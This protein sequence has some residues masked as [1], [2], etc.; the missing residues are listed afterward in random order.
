[1]FF[2]GFYAFGETAGLPIVYIID[3]TESLSVFNG[4]YSPGEDFQ[5]KKIHFLKLRQGASIGGFCWMVGWLVGCWKKV[6]KISYNVIGQHGSCRLY[7]WCL[8]GQNFFC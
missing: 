1:M 5:T 8:I 6:W 4:W 7:C 2:H 3:I